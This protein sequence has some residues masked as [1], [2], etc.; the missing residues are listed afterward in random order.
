[1]DTPL[2]DKQT[3]LRHLEKMDDDATFDDIIYELYLL[4]K[5][6]R[7]LAD[8]EG[9]RTLSHDEV[10]RELFERFQVAPPPSGEAE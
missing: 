6:R 2:T 7:G 9:G 1:M 4:Y 8:A 10:K 3:V 5:V